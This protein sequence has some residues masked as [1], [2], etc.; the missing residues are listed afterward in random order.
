MPTGK[1]LSAALAALI[2]SSLA[3]NAATVSKQNGSVFVNSG[4]G[5]VELKSSAEVAA[6]QRVMV[7]PGGSASIAYAGNCTV[8]VGSGVWMVQPTAPCKDGATEID[9]TNRM[10]QATP[11][12]G[13]A[14]G[15]V[16]TGALLLGGG[17]GAALLLWQTDKGSSP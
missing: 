10:N 3:A 9:F 4:T 16:L 2:V 8:R 12:P 14:P 17:V 11:P 13:P 15:D 7:Q 5:F 6:G 1:T